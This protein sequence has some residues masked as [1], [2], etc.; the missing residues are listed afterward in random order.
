MLIRSVTVVLACLMNVSLA[1]A[2]D[3]IG[4]FA[5]A[6]GFLPIA[7]GYFWTEE[8][9]GPHRFPHPEQ[10]SIL[11]A[12]YPLS[13]AEKAILAID[14]LE[15]P[16][17]HVR[18]RITSYEVP[19]D[20]DWL[21]P[22]RLVEITRF[23]LGPVL[24]AD[25][26]ANYDGL[27]TPA[28]ADPAPHVTWR[29]VF[30]SDKYMAAS[31]V[32]VARRIMPAAEAAEA[33]C[34]G[35]PCLA[36]TDAVGE[37]WD[38]TDLDVD[39]TSF[40]APYIISDASGVSVPARIAGLLRD[41]VTFEGPY[42]MVISSGVV[43]QEDSTNGILRY[44]PFYVDEIS[45]DWL[46]R[47]QVAGVAPF[48]GQTRSARMPGDPVWN[49]PDGFDPG[50]VNWTH[51]PTEGLATWG[52]TLDFTGLAGAQNRYTALAN[53]SVAVF[54]S[55]QWIYFGIAEFPGIIYARDPL[56]GI[57]LP[58]RP[59]DPFAAIR[60]AG[61][62]ALPHRITATGRSGQ[63]HDWQIQEYHL[64]ASLPD[65]AIGRYLVWSGR[66]WAIA[67]LPALSGWYGLPGAPFAGQGAAFGSLWQSLGWDLSGYGLITHADFS[68]HGGV[69]ESD[70]HRLLFEQAEISGILT[71][72]PLQDGMSLR[73][74]DIGPRSSWNMA[75]FFPDMQP[76]GTAPW[77]QALPD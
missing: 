32:A 76:L 45:S 74:S 55:D 43:G 24:Q 7:P 33:Q 30:F 34:F 5:R 61:L 12:D 3:T 27:F 75:K 8:W 29:W 73:I 62:A 70:L 1:K 72:A 38:W 26:A 52:M 67:N 53:A 56:G 20:E 65:P 16:L 42:E 51:I 18:Y 15:Q 19:A 35:L 9:N 49:M 2:D 11:Q 22:Y 36:L 40:S 23:N 44:H 66:F 31:P 6:D 41:A 14:A 46:I 50:E 47:Q 64:L 71:T 68:L 28:E 63:L 57:A 17:P 60:P 59:R 48:W 10:G 25:V 4:T 58:I 39:E 13:D 21:S 69:S 37:G 54:E 77:P